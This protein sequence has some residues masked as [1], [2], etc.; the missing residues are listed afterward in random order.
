MIKRILTLFLVVLTINSYSQKVGYV[1]RDSVLLSLPEMKIAQQEL[2]DYLTFAE[3]ELEVMQKD[4]QEKS[5]IFGKNQ[6]TYSD[7]VK[8][9]KLREITDLEKR[10][11]DFQ[12]QAQK[13]FSD[14]QNK[15]LIPIEKKFYD[16][17][18]KVRKKLGY[19]VVMNISFEILYVN[20][21]FIITSEVLAE[22]GIK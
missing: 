20:P 12:T 13:E 17:V 2:N 1:H 9:N 16:A 18:V 6:Q 8:S 3:Q 4:Y 5:E 10:I 19:D 15:L 14:K 7:A 22:L 21:K 11:Q